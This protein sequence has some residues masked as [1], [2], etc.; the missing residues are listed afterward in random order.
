MIR[1]L[2]LTGTRVPHR[3]ALPLATRLAE[4][5]PAPDGALPGAACAGTDPDLFHP[6]PDEDAE[7]TEEVTA[8]AWWAERR[9]KMICAG[10]PV[11]LM[12][13]DG[14]LKRHEKHGILGGLTAAERDALH[15]RRLRA[16]ARTRR[17][18]GG[19]A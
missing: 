19:A 2:Y 10:C 3:S 1:R 14:A 16:A 12:C 18:L 9:A 17:A 7:V 11:R 8:A 6:G 15:Q 4:Y 5:R 13:L